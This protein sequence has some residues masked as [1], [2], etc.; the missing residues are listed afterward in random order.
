MYPLN[1]NNMPLNHNEEKKTIYKKTIASNVTNI[2]TTIK[3][4]LK[5]NKKGHENTFKQTTKT[6]KTQ[7]NTLQIIFFKITGF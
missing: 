5:K 2:C 3:K 4:I 1:I 7:L 6:T